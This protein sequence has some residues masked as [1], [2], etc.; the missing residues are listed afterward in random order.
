MPFLDVSDVLL[1]PDFCDTTLVCARSAQTVGADGLAAN[2]TTTLPFSGV[3]TAGT[4]NNLVRTPV[5]EYADGDILIV[6]KFRLQVAGNG[7][8]ADVVTW[9][10]ATYTVTKVNNYT[11]YG[12]GFVWA[13]CTLLPLGGG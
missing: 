1:D 9:N 6:T 5:G 11:T 10:G 8:D 3:V 4:G 2:A 12:A 13:V 7:N